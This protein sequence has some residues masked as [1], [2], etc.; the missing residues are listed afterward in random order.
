M[1]IAKKQLDELKKVKQLLLKYN[2]LSNEK[3]SKTKEYLEYI[4]SINCIFNKLNNKK[5]GLFLKGP[6]KLKKK[7][8]LFLNK[9]SK[10]SFTLKGN[11]LITSLPENIAVEDLDVFD[12]TMW[13]ATQ[14]TKQ[15]IGYYLVDNDLEVDGDSYNT[16]DVDLHDLLNSRPV[17]L[18]KSL[19]IHF[20]TERIETPNYEKVIRNNS[21]KGRFKQNE[22]FALVHTKGIQK[23]LEFYQEQF[24]ALQIHKPEHDLIVDYDSKEFFEEYMLINLKRNFGELQVVYTLKL[25]RT[26]KN[27]Y[28]SPNNGNGEVIKTD[29]II[30]K[31]DD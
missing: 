30:L 2:R 15:K 21:W 26:G 17:I 8:L 7:L 9:N 25:N 19:I 12:S 23:E 6:K 18:S 24:P 20:T 28:E 4:K 22:L 27:T 5:G 1:K 11:K 10:L 3:D 29:F 13:N 14:L 16:G 31:K